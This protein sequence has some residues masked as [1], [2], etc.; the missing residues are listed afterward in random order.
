MYSFIIMQ[1]GN[2]FIHAYIYSFTKY[3]FTVCQTLGN[4]DESHVLYFVMFLQEKCYIV[5]H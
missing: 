5:L 3:I 2:A 4:K 1:L